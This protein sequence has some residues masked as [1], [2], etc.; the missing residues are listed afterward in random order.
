MKKYICLLLVG[1]FLSIYAFP[2]EIIRKYS[3]RDFR[4]EQTGGYNLFR[5]DQLM[6]SGLPGEP[7]LPYQTVSLLLP[8]GHVAASVEFLGSGFVEIPGTYD[9]YP[10]QHVQPL[11]K[12]ADGVFIRK[13]AVYALKSAYPAD[14][15]GAMLTQ[16]LNG[17]AFLLT[18][19]TPVVYHPADGKIGYYKEVTLR[20]KTKPDPGAAEALKN[21]SSRQDIQQRVKSLAQN[22]E[23]AEAYPFKS[24]SSNYDMLIITPAAYQNGFRQLV[25]LYN[26][27]SIA[28]QVVTTESIYGSMTGQD[29]PEKIRNFI[30]QEY[31]NNNILFVLLGGDVEL[32]PYRGFYCYVESSSI[33]EEYNIPSDL[34]YSSLDGNW[35]TNNNWMWGEPGEDDLPP[36]VSVARM[37]FGDDA[38]LE[39]M[40]HKSE[41]YQTG[42]VPGEFE[43]PL[44]VGEYLYNDP[45]TWGSDYLELLIG[46]HNDNGYTT[47]GIPESDDI[48][49]LYE[50]NTGYVWSTD[51]L[52]QKINEGRSFI[53][54]CGH[55]NETYVAKLYITDITNANF[56]NVNGTTH[57]YTNFYSHGC[58]CG[59]FDYN[60]CIAEKM[61]TIDNFLATAVVNSR[62]GWFNQGQTEGPSAHLHRE[63][64]N[65]LYTDEIRRIGSTQVQSK[66]KTAP[67]VTV[68]GQFEP[69]AQRW[70]FYCCNVLGDPAMEI[71]TDNVTGLPVSQRSDFI[72]NPYPN[73]ASKV[74]HIEI[75]D[76]SSHECHI[77]ILSLTG[78]KVFDQVILLNSSAIQV[79][80]DGM[81]P[82]SYFC[83][84]TSNN[85]TGTVKII[86]QP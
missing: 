5:V 67:W 25:N 30:I 6:L 78:Q 13:D 34:Y 19:F 43:R 69:G 64:V 23:A 17:Y 65:A 28:T 27:E 11:S 37:P 47:N 68:P 2:D 83:R 55:A 20:V 9:L 51:D 81:A 44:M 24:Q 62:Y 26:N 35:N 58:L 84:V 86:I 63:F 46:L 60:D 33:Y 14:P 75:P 53:H 73:P 48:F 4:I 18:S 16:Y 49:R 40:I 82:G 56:S 38:E 72:L 77:E 15:K 45:I 61:V 32:V 54:H 79:P 80:L 1:L 71:Q 85:L 42:F 3:F 8:P 41:S 29:Q 52:L 36:E 59:S 12:G 22:R 57:N 7:A 21:L 31:Q 74:L 10:Q 76:M 70:C 50:D 66:I 39:N